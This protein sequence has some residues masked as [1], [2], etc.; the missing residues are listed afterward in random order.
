VFQLFVFIGLV[1]L[2]EC[3]LVL[4]SMIVVAL[5]YIVTRYLSVRMKMASRERARRM[6]AINSL[7]EESFS[8]IS[9]MQAFNQEENESK[10][11]HNQNLAAFTAKMYK[12]RLKSTFTPA[13]ALIETIGTLIVMVFGAFLLMQGEVT[14]GIL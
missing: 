9:L 2:V 13:V 10:K 6:G 7:T 8:N 3:K 4:S 5:F 12:V 1:F 14:I 11:F